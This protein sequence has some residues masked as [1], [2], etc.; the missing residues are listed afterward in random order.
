[1]VLISNWAN[2]VDY[3][4]G[5]SMIEKWE[6]VSFEVYRKGTHK[7]FPSLSSDVLIFTDHTLTI[8]RTLIKDFVEFFPA[9]QDN[10]T[11][12]NVLSNAN[13]VDYSKSIVKKYPSGRIRDFD[14][15]CFILE[16]VRD[17]HIFKTPEKSTRIYVSDAFR[18]L[19]LKSK[20]KGLDFIE[21][22][23]SDETEEMEHSRE[24]QFE[25]L[26]AE[27]ERN[28]GHEHSWLEA[29]VMVAAGKAMASGHWKIQA[30]ANGNLLTGKLDYEGNYHWVDPM[31]IPPI[32]FDLM[33][34]EAGKSEI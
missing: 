23:D 11:V 16:E 2:S 5:D 27:I 17:L 24:K 22:W 15:L 8:L 25:S 7:D 26:L 32:L 14:K 29:V 18:D 31:F 4:T 6:P 34:H 21:V 28:K 30:E 9:E 1:M 3:F 20:L 10:L 12:V 19:V 13:C 33:W